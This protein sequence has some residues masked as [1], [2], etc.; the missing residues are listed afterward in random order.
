MTLNNSSGS[1]TL[2]FDDVVNILHN[3]EVCRKSTA[4]ASSSGSTLNVEGR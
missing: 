2:K 1:D 3:E 4:E